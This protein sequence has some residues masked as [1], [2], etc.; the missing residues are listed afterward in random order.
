MHSTPA[1]HARRVPDRL[2]LAAWLTSPRVVSADGSV[3]AWWN[4]GHPGFAY[5][6]AAGWWLAWAWWRA[7]RGDEAPEPEQVRAVARRLAIDVVRDGGAGKDGRT[8]L[9]D[10]CVV[11]RGLARAAAAGALDDV[12]GAWRGALTRALDRFLSQGAVVLPAAGEPGRWSQTWGAH[13]ERA[14]GLLEEAHSR[15]DEPRWAQA[16][17]HIRARVG[18]G[19]AAAPSDYLHARLYAAEGAWRRIG[20]ARDEGRARAQ[21]SAAGLVA[22][23]RADGSLPAW[24]NGTGPGRVDAT[25]QA[26]RLWCA[27]GDAVSV[28]AARRALRW[29]A[30]VQRVDGAL[31]YEAGSADA[32]TWSALF[33]DYAA[34]AV[35]GLDA[36]A[37][38]AA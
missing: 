32:T 29:L 18:G 12:D 34:A 26:A 25:A 14:A 2:A 1:D 10:A 33:T 27:C 13:L 7:A 30:R 31:P 5:P 16:A 28:A 38:G 4:P 6:E 37:P 15:L 8:Y 9:F 22:W 11:A 20:T 21:E 35:A 3:A 17:G 24:A 23:Q 19:P 36:A